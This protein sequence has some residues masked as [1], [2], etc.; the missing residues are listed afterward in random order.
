VQPHPAR[1]ARDLGSGRGGVSRAGSHAAS[2]PRNIPSLTELQW[3]LC[4]HCPTGYLDNC[5]VMPAAWEV[6]YIL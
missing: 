4:R 2:L 3:P 1:A 6:S 5:V